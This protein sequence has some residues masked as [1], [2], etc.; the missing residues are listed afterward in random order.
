MK[1]IDTRDLYTRKCELETLRDAVTAAQEELE[2]ARIN[3]KMCRDA[4]EDG[5]NTGDDPDDLENAFSEAESNLESAEEDYGTDEKEELAEL[6][7]L[8]SEISGFMHGETMVPE[9]DFEDYAQLLA[10]DLGDYDFNAKWPLT[11]IDWSQAADELKQD[12][13][14]VTYQGDTYLVRA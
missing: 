2:E 5:E 1:T 4:L 7:N 11:C 10:E 12:Y 13:T 8:E 14:E 3:L 9:S 6:E